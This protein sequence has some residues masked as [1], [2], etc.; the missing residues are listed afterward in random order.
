MNRDSKS[1]L[2]RY[3][4]LRLGKHNDSEQMRIMFKK[5]FQA[6]TYREFWWYW[7]PTYGFFLGKYIY[8]PLRKYL[9]KSISVVFTFLVCGLILH[10]LP[11]VLILLFL[12]GILL[13]FPI[14]I[15]FTILGLINI[16][17][18]K[19]KLTFNKIRPNVRIVLH[20]LTLFSSMVIALTI[21][22]VILMNF[23][24]ILTIE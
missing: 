5:A 17:S 6:K 18:I 14:T 8:K 7:N 4:N 21:T 19:Y 1:E 2:R 20:F 13:P 24:N 12:T 23:R 11:I 22:K 9:P 16:T 3:I 15:F 10:D